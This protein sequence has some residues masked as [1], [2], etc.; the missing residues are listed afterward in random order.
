MTEDLI[1]NY[2]KYSNGVY[3]HDSLKYISGND[4]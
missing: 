3:F 4:I 1:S 2:N